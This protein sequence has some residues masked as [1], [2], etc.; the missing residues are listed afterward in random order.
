MA[1]FEIPKL[2]DVPH[3]LLEGVRDHLLLQRTLDLGG[4]SPSELSRQL[5]ESALRFRT[6]IDSEAETALGSVATLHRDLERRLERLFHD[7]MPALLRGA[8]AV[9]EKADPRNEHEVIEGYFNALAELLINGVASCLRQIEEGRERIRDFSPRDRISVLVEISYS[10]DR[11]FMRMRTEKCLSEAVDL[12]DRVEDPSERTEAVQS[13]LELLRHLIRNEWWESLY[14]EAALSRPFVNRKDFHEAYRDR[15]IPLNLGH[16][17]PPVTE[18]SQ[19]LLQILDDLILRFG[20]KR[21]LER[22]HFIL[23]RASRFAR[24]MVDPVVVRVF[25]HAIQVAADIPETQSRREAIRAIATC[26]SQV[27]GGWR[28]SG[29]KAE[30]QSAQEE[31][32]GDATVKLGD[33]LD[34]LIDLVQKME[35]PDERIREL[36]FIAGTVTHN[37]N[38]SSEVL[39]KTAKGVKELETREL[40]AWGLQ[41]TLSSFT[42]G[43]RLPSTTIR[44]F[45]DMLYFFETA[46]LW[47]EDSLLIRMAAHVDQFK[48]R[49]PLYS[50]SFSKHDY[51]AWQGI[52][53]KIATLA[54]KIPDPRRRLGVLIP[55]AVTMAHLCDESS[56]KQRA[57]DFLDAAI[58][59]AADTADSEE[60]R[61]LLV[62][63]LSG[64]ARAGL[65]KEVYE[66]LNKTG[67]SLRESVGALVQAELSEQA[68]DRWIGGIKRSASTDSWYRLERVRETSEI[69]SDLARAGLTARVIDSVRG[70]EDRGLQGTVFC[71]IAEFLGNSM[72]EGKSEKLLSDLL[73]TA[74][75]SRDPSLSLTSIAV[76]LWETNQSAQAAEIFN[77]AIR[78][79]GREGDPNIRVQRLLEIVQNLPKEGFDGTAGALLSMAAVSARQIN[80]G[81]QRTKRLNHVSYWR[82]QRGLPE[83]TT[84]VPSPADSPPAA[85][86]IAISTPPPRRGLR[87][88]W[89]DLIVALKKLLG[90]WRH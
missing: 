78:T 19:R 65:G 27:T 1:P 63:A 84:L 17:P 59:I 31:R 30:R 21:G 53:E 58:K 32:E 20:D 83:A 68:L 69:A 73:E 11:A 9:V 43:D 60:R 45:D 13:L 74:R 88:L 36:A 33:T 29:F 7:E 82:D 23:D 52:L 34:S 35:P 79:A 67:L 26:L 76:G 61:G 87:Q 15:S 48:S 38:I 44:L 8:F 5:T 16:C 10:F 42:L 22:V 66:I 64:A 70:L 41:H 54:V 6:I 25:Q 55:V 14:A 77:E 51:L 71:A 72:S 49:R 18:L 24:Y 81:D 75:A 47:D 90:G 12:L 89:V 37:E 56:F 86:A 3:Y 46:E 85:S 50:A 39:W 57:L 80:D 2:S 4:S 28:E 40:K 62:E